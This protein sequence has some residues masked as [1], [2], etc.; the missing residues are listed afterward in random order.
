MNY[1]IKPSEAKEIFTL[2]DGNGN[3]VADVRGRELAEQFA[4]LPELLKMLDGLVIEGTVFD[5]LQYVDLHKR[6]NTFIK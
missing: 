2:E 5:Y 1:K 3:P 6:L 4:A